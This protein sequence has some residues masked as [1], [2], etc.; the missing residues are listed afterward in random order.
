MLTVRTCSKSLGHCNY[1][2]F[3]EVLGKTST[4]RKNQRLLAELN[5]RLSLSAS[6]GRTALS[7]DFLFVLYRALLNLLRKNDV[8]MLASCDVRSLGALR[9]WTSMESRATISWW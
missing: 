1:M 3:P 6:L 5:C 9:C 8:G 4:I 7:M 2:A